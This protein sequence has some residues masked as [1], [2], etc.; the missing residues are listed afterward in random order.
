MD[1]CKLLQTI[2]TIIL[3]VFCIQYIPLESRAS[4]SVVKLAVSA[5]SPIVLFYFTLKIS[6][7]MFLF[8]VYYIY[9]ILVA[10]F[11]PLTFR[12]STMLYLGTYIVTF[13]T[14]YNL[15]V[16]ENVFTKSYFIRFLRGLIF[17]YFIT[18]ILQQ[19][20]IIIG[21]TK[22]PLINLVQVFN[23]GIGANS[24]SY[25]PSTAA[26]IMS[27]AYL[28]LLRMY[29]LEYKRKVTLSEMFVIA[30]WP[31]LQFLWIMLSMV[32]GTAIIGLLLISS[33]FIQP[34][35]R[36]IIFVIILVLIL[37][38]IITFSEYTPIVRMRET[39]LAFFSLDLQQ[40]I[41][42]DASSAYRTQA[43]INTINNLDLT[44]IEA[45]FG[46]GIDYGDI[47]KAYFNQNYMIGRISEF[48]LVSYLILLLAIYN[49]MI[50]KLFSL[51]T[52]FWCVL[53]LAT[54]NN[55][56]FR[57]GALMLFTIV[58]HF[59]LSSNT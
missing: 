20:F 17:A 3:I 9:V 13:I 16:F 59:Q 1:R 45:W 37:F 34:K 49:S 10:M 52:I 2:A 53:L 31:T 22:F 21:I 48:G 25:E 26:M 46:H 54:L 30:K 39:L 12:W 23:R 24:L 55:E 50:N 4:I 15:I 19:F 56:A 32:S 47:N 29:E 42:A 14:F 38:L 27:F 33:Y 7:T 5:L 44:T 41:K 28:S 8:L 51:E 11:Y 40:S 36:N 57:W 35:P 43:W 58:R 18:L 6:K